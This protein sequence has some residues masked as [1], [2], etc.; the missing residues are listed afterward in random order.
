MSTELET[1]VWSLYNNDAA[2]KASLSGGFHNTEAEQKAVMPFGVFQVISNTQRLTFSEDQE[3]FLLQIKVFSDK[4]SS[5]ELNNMYTQI[6]RVF[7]FA[8]FTLSGYTSIYCKRA[9]AIK[10]KTDERWQYTTTYRIL[11]EK[12]VS[13]R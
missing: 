6:K 5:S 13:V 3:D 1:A 9:H 10:T 12:D 2:L 7:D 11:I 4:K 8:V